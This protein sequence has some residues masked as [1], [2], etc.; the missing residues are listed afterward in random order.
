MVLQKN[1]L[2]NKDAPYMYGFYLQPLTK[3]KQNEQLNQKL[4]NQDVKNYY[5]L[6]NNISNRIK[7]KGVQDISEFINALTKNI[8]R[9]SNTTKNIDNLLK[10]V[11]KNL[12]IPNSQI[13]PKTFENET[14]VETKTE[15]KNVLEDL[16]NKVETKNVLE[17]LI[18][19]EPKD[20]INESEEETKN[21]LINKEPKDFINESEEETKFEEVPKKQNLTE[22][23]YKDVDNITNI[24]DNLPRIVKEYYNDDKKTRNK[25]KITPEDLEIIIQFYYFKNQD[26][27]KGSDM[28]DERQVKIYFTSYLKYRSLEDM[29]DELTKS[30]QIKNE[31][32]TKKQTP[33]VNT[34][35]EQKLQQ[36]SSPKKISVKKVLK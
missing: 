6:Y 10:L 31:E 30:L 28:F 34:S 1:L 11:M 5:A 20:I 12:Q 32:I 26:R 8:A 24:R 25:K 13:I 2:T 3:E 9:N 14:K 22:D 16:L 7:N 29:K 27:L 4:S 23:F 33:N 19:K 18:N 35:V 15:V 21:D 36:Q 17:D